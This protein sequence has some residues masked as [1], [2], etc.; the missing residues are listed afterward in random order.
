[1]TT[2]ILQMH[3]TPLQKGVPM[4][5]GNLNKH[6]QFTGTVYDVIVQ[7]PL[8]LIPNEYNAYVKEVI[9]K[10]TGKYEGE[11]EFIPPT[12]KGG[13]VKVIRYLSSCHSLDKQY[14]EKN[15]YTPSNDEEIIGRF[16]QGNTVF[17]LPKIE[18]NALYILFLSNHPNNQDNKYR[19][20]DA[21]IY[22]RFIDGKTELK[23]ELEDLA[24]ENKISEI[25]QA[26]IN[27]DEY[28]EIVSYIFG[29]NE[30]IEISSRKVQLIK[31][32]KSDEE[33]VLNTIDKFWDNVKNNFSYLVAKKAI[34]IEDGII[35]N[36]ATKTPIYKNKDI[37]A[38][39][40]EDNIKIFM[41]YFNKVKNI[42]EWQNFEK[43]NL[44]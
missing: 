15:N 16:F 31:K 25:K 27:N 3:I 8:Q 5:K 34:L 26:I 11:L 40:N 44:N 4:K 41:N 35:L 10:T 29:L 12:E 21:P 1:M 23:N 20:P 39:M 36:G 33:S 9:D 13:K 43:E 28:A 24:K 19:K 30:G 18:M 22:F 38:G 42:K 14:Q 6:G 17:N 7:P 37:K 32:I 2:E